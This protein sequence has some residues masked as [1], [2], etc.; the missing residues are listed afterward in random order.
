MI[1][2]RLEEKDFVTDIEEVMEDSHTIAFAT[3]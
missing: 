3:C 1:S 2:L